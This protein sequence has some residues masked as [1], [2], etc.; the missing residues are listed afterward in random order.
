MSRRLVIASL[1]PISQGERKCNSLRLV[2]DFGAAYRPDINDDNGLGS[3]LGYGMPD[4]GRNV[5][6]VT[7]LDTLR[8]A[9]DVQVELS[10][11]YQADLLA[12]VDA[13]FGLR[14]D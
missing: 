11:E 12:I 4:T 2:R 9:A 10:I 14:V 1:I 3:N 5:E 6:G 13:A 8:L 7:L